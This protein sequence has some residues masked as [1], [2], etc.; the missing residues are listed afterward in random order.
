MCTGG[1][2]LSLSRFWADDSRKL[3]HCHDNKLTILRAS[4]NNTPLE[5]VNNL[6]SVLKFTVRS[7]DNKLTILR[8]W[9][10]PF[11]FSEQT[12]T[13]ALGEGAYGA[14]SSWWD[15]NLWSPDSAHGGTIFFTCFSA[16]ILLYLSQSKAYPEYSQNS[17]SLIHLHSLFATITHWFYWCQLL[18][19]FQNKPF[20]SWSFLTLFQK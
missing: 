11:F 18:S 14:L 8:I 15:S 19:T 1:K 7:H 3:G 6:A 10:I 12:S 5:Q 20:K 4:W 9:D 2:S 13:V 16:N 17:T